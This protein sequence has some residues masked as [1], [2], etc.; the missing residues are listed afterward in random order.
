LFAVRYGAQPEEVVTFE[1]ACN[2]T[3]AQTKDW[4]GRIPAV[5]D[6]KNDSSLE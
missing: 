1:P 3:E 6:T 4:P 2:N 5:T